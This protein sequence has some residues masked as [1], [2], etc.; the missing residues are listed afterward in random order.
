VTPAVLGPGP[1]WSDIAFIPEIIGDLLEADTLGAHRSQRLKQ[2]VW[3]YVKALLLKPI[4]ERQKLLAD[5]GV[6]AATIPR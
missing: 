1:R 4:D 3:C 2:T 5:P 6:L